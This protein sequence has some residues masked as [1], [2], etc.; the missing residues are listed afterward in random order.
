MIAEVL[1]A[2]GVALEENFW[3]RVIG[4]PSTFGSNDFDDSF[5]ESMLGEEGNVDEHI[6]HT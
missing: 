5:P 2:R 4:C 6:L 3:C 1:S